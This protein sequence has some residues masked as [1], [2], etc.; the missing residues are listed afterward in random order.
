MRQVNLITAIGGTAITVKNPLFI[1]FTTGNPRIRYAFTK[2]SFSGI[3]D[4]TWT[5]A[6]N[7][8]PHD[9]MNLWE[10]TTGDVRVRRVFR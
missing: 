7:H 10:G 9:M 5:M 1:D 8:G 2:T 3:E 4:L 6:D